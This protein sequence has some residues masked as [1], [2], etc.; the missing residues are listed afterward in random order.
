MSIAVAVVLSSILAPPGVGD[1][2]RGL[3]LKTIEGE[4]VTLAEVTE[5]G[6]AVVLVLRGY[7]G[8]QCPICSR[9]VADFMK[10]AEA[11]EK[12]GA[13][14]VMIYPGDVEDLDGKAKEFLGSQPLPPHFKFTLDPGYTFTDAWELRWDAPRET[15]YPST[16]LVDSEGKVRAAYVSL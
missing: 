1:D 8:Y 6:P 7:P 11:F 4:T 2:A 3:S 15:A 13:T 10:A 9:Q 12:A 5:K 16:F 14:V